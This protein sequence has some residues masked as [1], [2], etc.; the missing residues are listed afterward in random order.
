MENKTR[1]DGRPIRE[2]GYYDPIR[3][4]CNLQ[5]E[6]IKKWL[7]YGVKPTSTV[8]TILKKSKII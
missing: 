7:S 8:L 2:L 3:K 1:R 4:K 6:E 5:T